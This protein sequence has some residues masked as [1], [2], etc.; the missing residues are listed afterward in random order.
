[1]GVSLVMLSGFFLFSATQSV[2]LWLNVAVIIV[3][4]FWAAL[5]WQMVIREMRIGMIFVF[6]FSIVEPVYI[7][8][9]IVSFYGPVSLRPDDGCTYTP[10]IMFTLFGIAAIILR[11]LVVVFAIKCMMNFDRGMKKGIAF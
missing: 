6:A 7:V 11:G 9:K 8:Y 2:A 10:C 1:M 4:F 5:G 3:S